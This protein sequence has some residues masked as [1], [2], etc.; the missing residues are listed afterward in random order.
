MALAS[1]LMVTVATVDGK[2]T[3]HQIQLSGTTID[4]RG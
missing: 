1:H 4:E 2:T 3:T